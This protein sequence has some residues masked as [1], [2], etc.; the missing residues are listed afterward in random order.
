MSIIGKPAC[1]TGIA[2][3]HQLCFTMTLGKKK[4]RQ[5]KG[6][7][8][9]FSTSCVAWYEFRTKWLSCVFSFFSTSWVFVP[10]YVLT[11]I[12]TISTLLEDVLLQ[13]HNLL[14]P[15]PFFFCDGGNYQKIS[16]K[17]AKKSLFF[18]I[19]KRILPKGRSQIDSGRAS[20]SKS[21]GRDKQVFKPPAE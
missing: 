5:R 18:H 12:T 8:W 10:F 14:P 4:K 7:G 20:V 1:G 3:S 9:I 13:I 19:Q 6:E 21:Q 16:K 11:I 2:S 17:S 15:P